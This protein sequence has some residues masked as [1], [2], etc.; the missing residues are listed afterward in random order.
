[1]SS[2]EQQLKELLLPKD[3]EQ[4][5]LSKRFHP[6]ASVILLGVATCSTIRPFVYSLFH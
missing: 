5:R 4:A 3:I 6:Q 2:L 1:M